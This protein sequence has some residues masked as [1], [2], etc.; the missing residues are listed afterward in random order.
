MEL[1]VLVSLV[2][3]FSLQPC[4]AVTEYYVRSNTSTTC[5][6]SSCLTLEEYVSDTETYFTSD[7]SFLFMEG[8]HYLS[9]DLHIDRKRNVSMTALNA[10][11]VIVIAPNVTVRFTNSQAIVVSS[12]SIYY[13]GFYF[14]EDYMTLILFDSHDV[15]L[16]NIEFRLISKSGDIDYFSSAV[17]VSSSTASITDCSFLND[18]AGI[19][20]ANAV[21]SGGAVFIADSTVEF[22]GFIS[23]IGYY[24]T[25][26][27]AI[28]AFNSLLII[29]GNMTFTNNR[30]AEN[31]GALNIFSRDMYFTAMNSPTNNYYE[32]SSSTTVTGTVTFIENSA[33]DYGGAVYVDRSNLQLLGDT[34]FVG[35]DAWTGGAIFAESGKITLS[36]TV[37]IA[38]NTAKFGGIGVQ[39]GARVY[40]GLPFEVTFLSNEAEEMGGAMYIH[41]PT[42]LCSYSQHAYAC[43]L[44]IT[45][46]SDIEVMDLN[47]QLNF[48]LNS[49]GQSGPAIYGG[50]LENCADE[51]LEM[52]GVELLEYI[53]YPTQITSV[54]I[55]SEPIKVCSCEN[56]VLLNCTATSHSVKVKRGEQFNMSLIT[57][58]QL[59]TPVSAQILANSDNG[60]DVQLDPQFP[61]S[62]G[63]CTNVGI[64][65]LAD[66]LISN[67]T[68]HL[69]PDGPCGNMERTRITVEITLED[70][71]PGFDLNLDH[72]DCERRLLSLIAEGT[73]NNVT[74]DINTETI[75]RHGNA[76]IRPI[77][78]TKTTAIILVS[79]GTPTVH[80]VIASLHKR[81]YIL[82]SLFLTPV[83]HCAVRTAMDYCV[84][85]AHI[86]TA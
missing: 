27:G 69:Y 68:L 16:D 75:L 73:E 29:Q 70:C 25:N 45:A 18:S 67:K 42:L 35:N 15:Q 24:A 85:R 55:S 62:D 59:D 71:P 46:A 49:A 72:C 9:S 61:V 17:A 65:L 60:G 14:S 47:A 22:L 40:F 2:L 81:P 56:G 86:T 11:V 80:L 34:L 64:T 83:T 28:V 6:T 7:T 51:V 26:G 77:F 48:L 37:D 23:F 63:T 58:G 39:R 76:W 19:E 32:G 1:H 53:T 10:N 36:M 44:G 20:G 31:G 78:G 13:Y 30:A 74:C 33:M 38:N 66:E 5:P 79:S 3:F 82:T 21:D 50:N 54:D 4:S 84:V 52:H 8:E 12:L 43:F 41:D 57:V